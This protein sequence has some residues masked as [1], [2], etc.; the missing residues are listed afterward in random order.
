[1]VLMK[2]RGAQQAWRVS[3][4]GSRERY[5]IHVAGPADARLG[6][7]E[8]CQWELYTEGHDRQRG[9]EMVGTE[10]ELVYTCHI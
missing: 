7:G 3:M 5:R 9:N 1:M 6:G 8:A 2:V 10:N 4:S